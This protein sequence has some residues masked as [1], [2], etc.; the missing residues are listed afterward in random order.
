MR[1][2]LVM[3]N[4][5]STT[6]DKITKAIKD[7]FLLV[8]RCPCISQCKGQGYDDGST[9]MGTLLLNLEKKN[10]LRFQFN[11]LHIVY[12]FACRMQRKFAQ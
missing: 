3:C 9:M 8:V 12:F 2:L 1:T 5:D 6:A 7:I 4:F 11:V 10:Q